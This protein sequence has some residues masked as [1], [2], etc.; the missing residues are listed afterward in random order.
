MRLPA[1]ELT[2][3][4]W[5]EMAAEPVWRIV[6]EWT[7]GFPLLL[8]GMML[9]VAGPDYFLQ[10]DGQIMTAVMAGGGFFGGVRRV[11]QA[12]RMTE[13]PLSAEA[14]SYWQSLRRALPRYYAGLVLGLMLG[15]GVGLQLQGIWRIVAVL[16]GFMLGSLGLRLRRD[17]P[18]IGPSQSPGL[19]RTLLSAELLWGVP[20]AFFS[21]A[22]A[23]LTP[24]HMS[25]LWKLLLVGGIAGLSGGVFFGFFMWIGSLILTRTGSRRAD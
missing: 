2:L 10:R 15:V 20:F 11:V 8:S 3:R 22:V 21:A 14:V 7:V 6:L 5:K 23:A 12:R 1:A 19:G 13:A 17:M 25:H 16:G 9:I 4:Y 24:S 18:L